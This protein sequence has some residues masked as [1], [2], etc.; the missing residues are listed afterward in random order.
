[1]GIPIARESVSQAERRRFR[2][3]RRCLF[4]PL[5][6]VE[7]LEVSSFLAGMRGRK[8]LV[9]LAAAALRGGILRPGACLV[10]FFLQNLTNPAQSTVCQKSLLRLGPELEPMAV[11]NALFPV[12][13]RHEHPGVTVFGMSVFGRLDC[14]EESAGHGVRDLETRSP[15]GRVG[16]DLIVAD[17]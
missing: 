6:K 3:A 15:A 5:D 10:F 16:I 1:M 9:A 8:P 7:R 13:N 2:L 14:L 12:E 11:A 17:L 4:A